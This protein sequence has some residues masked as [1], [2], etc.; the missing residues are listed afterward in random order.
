[1]FPVTVT[2]F[3]RELG[4]KLCK[5]LTQLLTQIGAQ[6]FEK[7][8]P[9]PTSIIN[10]LLPVKMVSVILFPSTIPATFLVCWP[11][12]RETKVGIFASLAV[13]LWPNSWGCNPAEAPLDT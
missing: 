6:G 2:T 13:R 1:M 9:K 8:S 12:T 4:D 10:S 5:Y 11:G 3:C 7:L